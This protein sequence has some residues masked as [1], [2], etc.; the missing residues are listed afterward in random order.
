MLGICHGYNVDQVR[1]W[2]LSAQKYQDNY[3]IVLINADGNESVHNFCNL[4]GIKTY[5]TLVEVKNIYHD[6][7]KIWHD[8]LKD[9]DYD[10]VLCTDVVDVIF[11]S[12][13]FKWIDRNM[14]SKTLIVGGEGVTV[15]E[16]D[17][18]TENIS[19]TFAKEK[20]LVMNNEVVCGGMIGGYKLDVMKLMMDIYYLSLGEKQHSIID[21]A[22]LNVALASRRDISDRMKI[23]NTSESLVA[24]LFVSGNQV[25]YGSYPTYRHLLPTM[26]DGVLKNHEGIPYSIVH[27]YNRFPDWQRQLIEK[28]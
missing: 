11:Q 7:H 4:N 22:A 2:A 1:H 24:H 6:R 19:R 13:P 14:G 25:L 9:K 27:Q 18:N 20:E 28:I 3:D 17:W 12:N 8:W 26:V 23:T 21:Q 10:F 16:Q 5:G 15:K